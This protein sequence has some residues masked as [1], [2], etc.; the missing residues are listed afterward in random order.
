MQHYISVGDR[1]W[2]RIDVQFPFGQAVAA[3]GGDGTGSVALNVIW[4]FLGVIV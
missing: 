2:R 1:Q 4:P 3:S